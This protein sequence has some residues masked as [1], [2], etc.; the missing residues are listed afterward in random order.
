MIRRIEEK[1]REVFIEMSEEFY[2]SPAVLHPVDSSFHTKAFD[3]LMRSKEYLECYITE[4]D[5]RIAGFCL[6]NKTYQHE[7]G[8]RVLWVEELYVRPEFQGKGL[9]SKMLKFVEEDNPDTAL[10]RLE[11]EPDNF[12]AKRLYERNGY[13]F[14]EYQQYIKRL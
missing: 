7:Y 8:G 11:T 10:I 13:E 9:G 3:E 5:S 1:D 12:G 6:L 4:E 14:L 2:H